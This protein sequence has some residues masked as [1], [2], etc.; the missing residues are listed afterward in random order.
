M[1][2][3][4]DKTTK[5]NDLA[6]ITARIHGVS[7]RYVQMILSGDRDNERIFETY[8]TLKEGKSKLIKAVEKAVK[9]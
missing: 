6:R 3:K 1:A 8:M 2:L 4:E 9:L 5:R 7:T